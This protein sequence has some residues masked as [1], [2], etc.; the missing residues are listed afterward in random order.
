M[1]SFHICDS[2]ASHFWWL[3]LPVPWGADICPQISLE[4]GRVS[5]DELQR[6]SPPVYSLQVPGG[7][8]VADQTSFPGGSGSKESACQ[9]RSHRRLGFYAWVRKIPWRRNPL[10]DS[11]QDNPLNREAWWA[12][13]HGVAE[14]DMTEQASKAKQTDKYNPYKQK[15]FRVLNSFDAPTDPE[16]KNFENYNSLFL[17]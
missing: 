3:I 6:G 12:T 1:G 4:R 11:S 9:C 13:V 10:Q 2:Y 7:S 16:T 14:S 8:F 15:P 5:P 17:N